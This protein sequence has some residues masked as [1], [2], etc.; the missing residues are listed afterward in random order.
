MCV[1]LALPAGLVALSS[2]SHTEDK[3]SAQR[4]DTSVGASIITNPAASD[5]SVAPVT[6]SPVPDAAVTEPATTLPAVT[7]V[8]TSTDPATTEPATAPATD[9]PVTE[10]PATDPPATEAPTT[11]PVVTLPSNVEHADWAATQIEAV[12]NRSGAATAA[13][14]QR[15]LDLGFWNQGADGKYGFSTTQSVMAFQKYAGLSASGNVDSD[16]A[17]ALTF[18]SERA[19]GQSNS[20]TLV[21]VDKAKQL[22]FVVQDGK[23]VWAFNTS[24]G[25]GIPYTVP[26]KI[27]PTKI[28]T[29][30]A[31]TPDGLFKTN[32]ERP[33]G[34]WVGDLGQIYRPKYFNG[35]IAIHGLGSIPNHPASH[36]CVRVST[37]AMDFIWDGN[38]VPL[39]TVVWVHS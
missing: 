17:F 20:G 27:D 23:T 5:T 18:A 22:L 37:M 2:C 7:D 35:G 34:W 3:V 25:S 14:Q 21:E 26:N 12:G 19:H 1:L 8:P 38:L 16:T 28:E 33:Q 31:Q 29:G 36:G 13:V 11:A 24:T 39:K 10:P 9:L 6:D 15:L 30:D 32:R 4:P